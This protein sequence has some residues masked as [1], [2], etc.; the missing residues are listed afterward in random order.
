M[1]KVGIFYGS[2]TGMTEDIARL[3]QEKLGKENADLLNVDSVGVDTLS[4]YNNLIFASST[5]GMGELQDD[6]ENFAADMDKVDLSGKK[7]AIFGVGDQKLYPDTFVDAIGVLY[8]KAKDC[9]AT[10]IGKVSTEGYKFE[11]SMGLIDDK[12]AGLPLDEENQPELTDSRLNKWIE[13]IKSS[14]N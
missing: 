9:G 7:V 1:T 5:W 14:F 4:K 13:E 2:S 3:V 10:I 8:K 6:W 12:F 11:K